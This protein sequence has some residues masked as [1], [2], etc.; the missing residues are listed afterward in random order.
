MLQSIEAFLVHRSPDLRPAS[1]QYLVT[2]LDSNALFKNKQ[3]KLNAI[4]NNNNNNNNNNNYN[5]Y[6]NKNNYYYCYSYNYNNNNNS[7]NNNN[8]NNNNNNYYYMAR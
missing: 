6:N 4:I 8:N 5:N 2:E 3:L 7:Y 1:F